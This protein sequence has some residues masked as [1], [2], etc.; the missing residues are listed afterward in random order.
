MTTAREEEIGSKI[1]GCLFGMAVGDALGLPREGLSRRRAARIF[2]APPLS[3][4]LLFG[5]GL[6]SDDTEH[7]IMVAEAVMAAQ[8]DAA[9]F[10]QVLA[11]KMRLWLLG[12][13]A[14]IGLATARAIIK[15]WL[16]WSP[17]HSGVFSAGNGPAMRAPLLGTVWAFG[18]ETL[19]EFVTVSTRMTHTDP[20]AMQGAWLIAEAARAG[21]QHGPL[22]DPAPLLA[23]W[24]Q[25]VDDPQLRD[26][27]ALIACHLA[28]GSTA[29]TFAEALGLTEGVSGFINHTVPV[30]LYVWL[31]YPHDF[32]Q[33]LEAVIT[34]GGD[35]DTTGAIVGGLMGATLGAEAI[36]EAWV[37]GI[38]EWPKTTRWMRLLGERLACHLATGDVLRP[39]GYWW[40]GLLLRN[41]AV[42][43]I[44][45]YH[46]LRRLCPPY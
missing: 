30:A 3:H 28:Q 45:L 16:G 2:G 10:A 15:L 12:I 44:V 18:P 4:Q 27:L 41:L 46:G 43:L 34:L 6:V 20:R 25:R 40:P 1:I 17:A 11:W 23:D 9:R 32:R 42:L 22:L 31:R 14:G 38:A 24:Q 8:G 35:A 19:S 7:A 26:A 36:P 37:R 13:P 39:P 5:H 33:A 29:D 21:T